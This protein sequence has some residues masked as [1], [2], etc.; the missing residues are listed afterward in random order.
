MYILTLATVG[1]IELLAYQSDVWKIRKFYI[2]LVAFLNIVAWTGF[3]FQ[4]YSPILSIL[5]T[6][7]C[8][9]RLLNY[10]RIARGRTRPE[11]LVNAG[12]RTSIILLTLALSVTAVGYIRINIDSSSKTLALQLFQLLFALILC[13]VSFINI[14]RISR[15]LKCNVYT[16]GEL[17]TVSVCIPARNE[18]EQ[19]EICINSLLASTYPKLEIIVLDDCSNDGTPE[20]IKNFAQKGVR[21]IKGHEP[22]ETWLPKNSAYQQLLESA[23]GNYVLFCGVDTRFAPQTITKLVSTGKTNGL[24]MISVLPRRLVNNSLSSLIQPMRYWWE[25]ALPRGIINSPP[26]LSTCW[27]INRHELV[28]IGGFKS[29]KSSVL[30]ERH[31]AK[32]FSSKHIYSFVK[33]SD[34]IDVQ[35]VKPLSDQRQ[36]ALRVRYP[37]V[38]RRPELILALFIYA[39]SMMLLPYILF[40]YGLIEL[41]AATILLSLATIL[42]NTVTHVAIV[43]ISNPSNV[44]IAII[45]YPV[46]IICEILI[47]IT[48]MIKYEFTSVTWKERNICQPVMK[49]IPRLPKF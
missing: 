21:F 26:V 41:D 39:T 24:E 34:L 23:T 11:R 7:I 18:T 44:P 4:A 8:A 40:V 43:Y 6:L 47:E 12:F 32:R 15:V 22:D 30:P 1:L 29:V 28:R 45:N 25:L 37:Q 33:S 49:A 38:R 10:A 14:R 31:I 46:V 20:I 2:P 5:F 17:P 19:L 13:S 3:Y 16:D 9:F 36:T 35:T 48:S 27:L 42:V